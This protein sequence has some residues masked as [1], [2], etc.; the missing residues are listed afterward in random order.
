MAVLLT[1]SETL[2]GS[3]VADSLSGGGTGVDLGQ[4]VNGQYS[5]IVNPLTN[6]EIGR[7]HV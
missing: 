6:D 2:S 3:E 7:A 5:P 4:V 1:I